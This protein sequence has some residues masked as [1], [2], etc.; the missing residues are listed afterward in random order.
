MSV[1]RSTLTA[2]LVAGL[3]TVTLLTGCGGSAE[4][5]ASS[6][7]CPDGRIRF[8]V[9]PFE[10]PARLTP[11][12]KVLADALSKSLD[13]P[14]E[15][16]ITEDYS[17]EVLAMENRKL[18][19]GIFGPLGYVFAAKRADAE[20]VASFGDADG[21]LSSYTAGIWVPAKSSVTSIEQLRGK[22]LALASIG[23]TSGD[24][25]P[26]KALLDAGLA[27]D[28]VKLNYA[29][30][31]PEAL[32]ALV[33]GAVDAAEINSQQLSSAKEAGTFDASKFRRIWNSDP[34]PNDPI[35]VRGD[36]PAAFKTAVHDALL[37]LDP[38]AVA[39]IGALLDVSPPG[40]LV[41]VDKSTYR[42]L[43]ELADSLGLTEKD[44]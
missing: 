28:D 12:A 16:T 20:A 33:N 24:A 18:D 29:G 4:S 6:A 37:G 26:R 10:D 22:S 27:K 32:L 23:S 11:A 5:A 30:G 3:A 21:K 35:T 2:A 39:E 19:I 43:F 42:P 1:R 38:A 36:L 40:P 41:T 7:T 31:H 14:V 25:L 15:L 9:E 13:C 34:I 44:V 17:A 8:G